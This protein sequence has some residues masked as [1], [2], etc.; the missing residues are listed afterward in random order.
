M[1][2]GSDIKKIALEYVDHFRIIF[3]VLLPLNLV[4]SQYA[5]LNLGIYEQSVCI[6]VCTQRQIQKADSHCSLSLTTCPITHL[7]EYSFELVRMWP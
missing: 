1:P 5:D 6:L 4:K 7:L 3:E 2:Q